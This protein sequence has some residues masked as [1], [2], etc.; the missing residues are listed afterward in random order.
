MYKD[1]K[2]LYINYVWTKKM[3]K[4]YPRSFNAFMEHPKIPKN[5][6]KAH[7]VC[8]KSERKFVFIKKKK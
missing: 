7:L 5:K 8:Q 3:S 2:L 1:E 6:R 4:N